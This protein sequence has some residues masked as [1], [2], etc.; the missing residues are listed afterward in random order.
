MVQ[1][2]N[3]GPSQVRS[4]LWYRFAFMQS[5]VSRAAGEFTL[6]SGTTVPPYEREVRI[7]NTHRPTACLEPMLSPPSHPPEFVSCSSSL[8]SLII[9]FCVESSTISMKNPY[10]VT[11]CIC[12]MVLSVRHERFA[13][14]GCHKETLVRCRE[15]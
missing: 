4:L 7:R 8:A 12:K 13:E 14:S 9:V 15:A 11:T 2:P 10:L 5:G 1:P 6:N 3:Q